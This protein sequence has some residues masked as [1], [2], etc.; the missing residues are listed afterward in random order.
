MSENERKENEIIDPMACFL[1][2]ESEE[3]QEDTPVESESLESE[4]ESKSEPEASD[5]E[6]RPERKPNPAVAACI[7]A[8][9][10]PVKPLVSVV[11]SVAAGVLAIAVVVLL[12]WLGTVRP[13]GTGVS[14]G[15][16]VERFNGV[17]YTD[18][19]VSESNLSYELKTMMLS[20]TDH[21]SLTED[22]VRALK[23]GES[24][25]L[26]DDQ[27]TLSLELRGSEIMSLS[28][29]PTD[30]IALFDT[31]S[32]S[33][34]TYNTAGF[35]QSELRVWTYFGKAISGINGSKAMDGIMSAYS[36]VSRNN[37]DEENRFVQ[38]IGDY[39]I[40]LAIGKLD[41]EIHPIKTTKHTADWSWF[42]E[43]IDKINIFAKKEEA[44]VTPADLSPSSLSPSELSPSSLTPSD[45]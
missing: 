16:F 30:L 36:T 13:C 31:Y 19:A 45:K 32:Q 40:S 14:L 8:G 17:T 11:V 34:I 4:P 33:D 22:D 15:E 41:L 2:D 39:C 9:S 29:S 27:M 12:F 23:R 6:L 25:K 5:S 44:V 26:F 37:I 18:Y 38:F 42:E 43:L 10:T 21:I 3:Q 1:G 28:I 35:G 20:D 7:K 24:V